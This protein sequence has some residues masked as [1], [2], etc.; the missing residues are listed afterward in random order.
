LTPPLGLNLF[1]ASTY[2]GKPFGEVIRSVLPFLG[3]LV[4]SLAIVTYVPTVSTGFVNLRNDRPFWSSFPTQD[5]CEAPESSRGDDE[6]DDDLLLSDDIFDAGGEG[7]DG[8]TEDDGGEK[9]IQDLMK[10]P[11]YQ[12]LL[13]DEVAEEEV[14]DDLDDDFPPEDDEDEGGASI[15]DLMKDPEY[16]KALREMATEE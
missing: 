16:R 9:S 2:F 8:M 6:E 15:Q 4:V 12:K 5:V 3:I 1:V 13:A 14:E 10:D 7:D 11:E